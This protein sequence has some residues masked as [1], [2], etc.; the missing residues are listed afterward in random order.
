[1]RDA[2]DLPNL[3][4]AMLGGAIA[5]G[6]AVL[7]AYASVQFLQAPTACLPPGVIIAG[8]AGEY[9]AGRADDV[10]SALIRGSLCAVTLFPV[11]ATIMAL[12]LRQV[13]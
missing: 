11:G 5:G 3:P 9:L 6:L 1:M 13:S 7:L 10:R 2:P 12:L 4:M 8:L